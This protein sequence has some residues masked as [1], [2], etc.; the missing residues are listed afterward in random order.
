MEYE[1]QLTSKEAEKAFKV[2]YKSE[3]TIT[4]RRL[5]RRGFRDGGYDKVVLLCLGGWMLVFSAVFP[6]LLFPGYYYRVFYI[7]YDLAAIFGLVL[8]AAAIRILV[9]I[10]KSRRIFIKEFLADP[11]T[12]ECHNRKKAAK[13]FWKYAMRYTYTNYNQYKYD[14]YLYERLAHILKWL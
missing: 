6:V 5:G 7:P 9:K 10:G 2:M 4:S 11:A 14:R 3:F 1:N 8:F 12:A 13:W